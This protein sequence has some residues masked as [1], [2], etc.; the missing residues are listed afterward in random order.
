M[1][2]WKIK[3]PALYD[4]SDRNFQEQH[5]GNNLFRSDLGTNSV[6]EVHH[7]PMQWKKVLFTFGLY[8]WNHPFKDF[9]HWRT[10]IGAGCVWPASPMETN[11]WVC[12]ECA[13]GVKAYIAQVRAKSATA[14][15]Y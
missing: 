10:S 8:R 14:P 5:L 3:P 6:C 15:P 1:G 12:A 4:P 13:S 7:V 11:I 2:A 9:P